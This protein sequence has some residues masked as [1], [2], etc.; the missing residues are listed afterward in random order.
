MVPLIFHCSVQ[1]RAALEG[2][3]QLWR[4]ERGRD[5]Q[6]NCVTIF[7]VNQQ[8]SGPHSHHLLPSPGFASGSRLCLLDSN[9][10]L[11]VPCL[12]EHPSPS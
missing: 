5:H 6:D 2:F 3:P 10:N 4:S 12:D 9:Y 7:M 1:E 11:L 8:T